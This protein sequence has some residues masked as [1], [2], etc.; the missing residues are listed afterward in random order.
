MQPSQL[1]SIANFIWGVADDVLRDLYVRGKY[2]D[3]ILPMTVLRRLDAVLEP[4]KQTVLDMKA[5]LDKARLRIRIRHSAKLRA[6][7]SRSS[8]EGDLVPSVAVQTPTGA[9]IAHD[10]DREWPPTQLDN[11]NVSM[12]AAS[13]AGCCFRWG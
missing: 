8:Q 3:V 5:S 12:T 13:A 1:T 9:F 7:P 4:T 11:R 10:L 2:R 6:R